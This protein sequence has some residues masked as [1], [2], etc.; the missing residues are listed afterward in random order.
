MKAIKVQYTVKADYVDTNT[1]NIRK[2]MKD[3]QELANPGIKYS[4]FLLKDGK[5][6]VHFGIYS[7]QA[8]LA[9]VDN[10]PS[11]HF[12]RDQLKASG[13]VSPPQENDLNLVDSSYEI[14]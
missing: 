5:T 9:E 12:F 11:F 13:P 14:F 2:V 10:L 7:D 4:A 1:R 6:F 3:L 8:A